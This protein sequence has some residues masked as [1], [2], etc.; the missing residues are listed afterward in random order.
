LR[1]LLW[2][3]LIRRRVRHELIG[4]LRGR[5]GIE[6]TPVEP[7]V[8]DVTGVVRVSWCEVLCGLRAVVGLAVGLGEVG[9]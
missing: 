1:K 6:P 3:W 9:T 2:S 4:G 8:V 7:T 5:V